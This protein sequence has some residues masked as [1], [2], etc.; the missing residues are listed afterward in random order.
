MEL[1]L[2]NVEHIFKMIRKDVSTT[3]TFHTTKT[4][5]EIKAIDWN[6]RIPISQKIK[7]EGSHILRKKEGNLPAT[8]AQHTDRKSLQIKE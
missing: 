8:A 2:M 4:H 3:I 6:S 5:D 7:D 1:L